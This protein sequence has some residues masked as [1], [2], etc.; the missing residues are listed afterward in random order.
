MSFQNLQSAVIVNAFFR[1]L[2]NSIV[3]FHDG[4]LVTASVAII[5]SWEDCYY[6]S[7]ML[8]LVTLHH[9]LMGTSNKMQS[10]YVSKLLSNILS[11]RVPR[12]ARR[13]TP[14]ASSKQTRC[15][16]YRNGSIRRKKDWKTYRSS[17]SDHT[18][19][20]MGPSCGTSCTRSK[21]RA[22]SR[23]SIDGERPP[24]KQKIRSEITAVIGR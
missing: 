19:S 2:I 23:V 15:C 18:K 24:C 17:G 4:S 7:I 14:T 13:N 5:G 3:H 6:A 1:C 9:Q 22:W 12:S 21:S 11:E 8:P 20:H 16:Q 10:V